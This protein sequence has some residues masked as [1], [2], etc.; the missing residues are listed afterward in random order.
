MFS[1]GLFLGMSN[2]RPSIVLQCTFTHDIFLHFVWG[3]RDQFQ[4]FQFI[5]SLNFICE[6][7]SDFTDKEEEELG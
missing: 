7:F 6:K 2:P 3:T 5:D 4:R 1:S